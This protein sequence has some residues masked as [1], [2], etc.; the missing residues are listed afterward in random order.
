QEV[1][2]EQLR[3]LTQAGVPLLVS[4]PAVDSML[5]YYELD[6]I[7]RESHAVLLPDLP[8]RLHPGV[9]QLTTIVAQGA[10]SP[11]GA[12]EQAIFERWPLAR[13]RTAVI[14]QFARD[15]DLVRCA[16][17]DVTRLA[18]LGVPD[19]PET[20][21]NLGVQMTVADGLAVR[22]SVGPVDDGA[23]ARLTVIGSRGKAILH[24]PAA[25]RWRLELRSEGALEDIKAFPNWNGPVEML[26][27]LQA[28]LAGSHDERAW[29]HAARS[30]E[31]AEAVERSLKR[32]RA[33]D[34]HN[35]DFTDIGTFKGTMTSLG[36][37]LLFGMLFLLGG[38][39]LVSYVLRKAGFVKLADALKSWPLWLAGVLIL[40]LAI[41]FL[42]KV[43]GPSRPRDETDRD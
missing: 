30:V 2:S 9:A 20:Y 14:R 33:V 10:E 42:L 34:L 32:G 36:C 12:A 8:W 40:F 39:A 35:E 18:A 24:M 27:A 41:Q 17:G 4:H 29:V 7:R 15:V 38:L 26:A 25:A 1:R 6:M 28:A 21:A 37:G 11:I 22:W 13:D 5:V 16:C 19:Q 31:L 43:A 3:K 23:G